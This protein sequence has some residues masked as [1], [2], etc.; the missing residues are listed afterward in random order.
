MAAEGMNILADVAMD[1]RLPWGGM[2]AT[3]T[4]MRTAHQDTEKFL[5]AALRATR[6]ITE[7]QNKR[8]VTSWIGKFFKLDEKLADEFYRR[9]VPSM[10]PAGSSSA[11]KSN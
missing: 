6:A 5:R 9:L 2:S 1:Y 7:P 3:Q 4:K 10:N 8:D 11:T